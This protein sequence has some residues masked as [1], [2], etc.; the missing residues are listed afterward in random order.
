MSELGDARKALKVNEAKLKVANLYV[1]HMRYNLFD[2]AESL[3]AAGFTD[4][5]II[6]AIDAV[7]PM[8][9][10]GFERTLKAVEGFARQVLSGDA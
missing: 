1:E 3:S 8:F 2:L 5:Q 10:E 6:E 4:A 9:Y 7:K